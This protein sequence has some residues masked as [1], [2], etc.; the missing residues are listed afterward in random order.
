[1]KCR[2]I[3]MIFFFSNGLTAQEVTYPHPVNYIELKIESQDV[4]LA[5]MD[6]KPAERNGKTVLLFHGKN[7]NGYYLKDVI[8]FLSNSGY[9]VIVPD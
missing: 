9:R 5:Y 6:V 1:M 7:F 8:S 2:L 3:G 4:K